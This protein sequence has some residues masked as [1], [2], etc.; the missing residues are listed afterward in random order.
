MTLKVTKYN[1][2]LEVK[3]EDTDELYIIK[4][5]CENT[6]EGTAVDTITSAKKAV[7]NKKTKRM[8]KVKVEDEEELHALEGLLTELFHEAGDE[9]E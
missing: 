3:D 6:E 9:E 5:E 7:L 1:V 4:A 8:N 2:E